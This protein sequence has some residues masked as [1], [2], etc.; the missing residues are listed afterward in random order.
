IFANAERFRGIAQGKD[1]C[2]RHTYGAGCVQMNDALQMMAV[3]AN[4]GTQSLHISTW[5]RGSFGAR[6]DEGGASAWLDD[7]ERAHGHVATDRLEDRIDVIHHAGE[8]VFVVVDNLIGTEALDVFVVGRARRGDD[9]GAEMLGQL[10]GISG[11]AAGTA[12]NEN[13]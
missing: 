8:V 3:A 9:T 12:L 13:G 1:A 2:L 4:R 5:R 10:N 11:H 6:R 7:R